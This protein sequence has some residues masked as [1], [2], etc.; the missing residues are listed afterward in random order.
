M[1]D[2]SEKKATLHSHHK[3]GSLRKETVKHTLRCL[4]GC[5][6]GEGIGAAI[7]FV[8]GMDMVSTLILAIG[9]AF[10]IGYAFTMIPMLRTMS[11]KRAAR[12]TAV[13]DT[14]SIAAMET[15]ENFARVC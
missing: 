2:K 11:L 14:V 15:A 7:G 5:N 3:S 10:V 8:L 12:V 9:L 4:L 6:I 13:G 1:V